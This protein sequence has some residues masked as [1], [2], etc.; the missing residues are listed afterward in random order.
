M[1]FPLTGYFNRRLITSYIGYKSFGIR[2]LLFI[3]FL[4]LAIL[5]TI[6]M[7]VADLG[8]SIVFFPLMLFGPSKISKKF[9]LSKDKS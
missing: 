3:P 4:L 9:L 8:F 7:I 5:L 1:L 6:V 2:L